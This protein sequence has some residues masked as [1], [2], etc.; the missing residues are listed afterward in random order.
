MTPIDNYLADIENL[1]E[2]EGLEHLRKTI[3]E[4]LPSAEECISYGM[5]AFRVQGNCVAGFLKFKHHLS[6]FPF[7]GTT[8]GYFAQELKNLGFEYTKS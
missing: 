1:A 2:R 5:P 8:L 3:H 7:S 6:F 4:I